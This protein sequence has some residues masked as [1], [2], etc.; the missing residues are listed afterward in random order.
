MPDRRDIAASRP[1]RAA[2]P[3]AWWTVLLA[4]YLAL[5]SSITRTEIAVGALAA[6]AGAA[7]AVATRRVLLTTGTAR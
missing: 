1:R 4:G 5:A 2:E 7:A 6:A 3:L